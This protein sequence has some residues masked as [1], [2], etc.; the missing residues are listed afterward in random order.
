MPVKDL[1][2]ISI[3][4]QSADCI[5]SEVRIDPAHPVFQG[6]F[7]GSPVLP[8]VIQLEMVRESVS[9]AL[10]RKLAMAELITCKFLEVL[11]PVESPAMTLDI[12]FKGETTLDVT[13]TGS[14][15]ASTFFKL[16]A[17]YR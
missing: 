1:Y 7:P 2:T 10:G 17:S 8:G 11:N 12:R 4:D 5:V 13:A 15:G 14:D 9:N 3:L 6:H 16:R